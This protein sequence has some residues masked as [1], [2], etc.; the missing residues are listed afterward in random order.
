MFGMRKDIFD[1]LIDSNRNIIISGDISSGKTSNIIFPLVDRLMS[2]EGNYLFLDSKEEY[3]NKYYGYLKSNDYNI[4]IINL[5]EADRSDGFNP[6]TYPYRLYKSGM[7]DK[8]V[9]YLESVANSIFLEKVNDDS[10]WNLSACDLF[11]GLSLILFKEANEE[12]VNINSV[13]LLLN[14]NKLR[15][16]VEKLDKN[17]AI[18]SCLSGN[19]LASS[20]MKNSIVSVFRQQL[21]K[22]IWMDLNFYYLKL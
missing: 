16:Y 12:E 4:I 3:I 19:I 1:R 20:D 14:S 7:V 11:I 2:R 10:F 18:Y 22:I 5:Q 9:E 21:R 6:L 13:N 15:D 17:S 8:A